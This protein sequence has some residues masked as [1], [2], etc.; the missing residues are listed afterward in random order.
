M[1]ASAFTA[2]GLVNAANNDKSDYDSIVRHVKALRSTIDRVAVKLAKANAAWHDDPEADDHA[3]HHAPAM[4]QY[5]RAIRDEAIRELV[6]Y[7]LAEL[8]IAANETD[9]DHGE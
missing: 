2:D 8:T 5:P 1:S 6:R 9:A 7:Y 4:E 3:A